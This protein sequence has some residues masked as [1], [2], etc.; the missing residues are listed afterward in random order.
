MMPAPE[1]PA[2]RRFLGRLLT[3]AAGLALPWRARPLVAAPQESTA[4]EGYLGEIMLLAF[5]FPPKNWA[6]CNGQLLSIA[7]NPALFSLL[8]T[9]YGGNGQTT[10]GLP[11]LR[12]RVAMHQ[13]QGAGLSPRS[14]GE[15]SGETSHTLTPSELP[16][17][18]HVARGSS[19]AGSVAMPGNT[20]V[21]ARN[22]AQIP[23]WGTTVDSA[24]S[25]PAAM[26]NV[27]G[28]QPHGNEQPYLVINYVICIAGVFP[29]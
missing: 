29:S 20:V 23:Q 10:F 24:L 5:N 3:L 27:G 21:P 14:M 15:R 26:T 4:A 1:T 28:N 9:T 17:H 13:G 19:A 22:A 6:L 16:S 18:T 11:D 7:Q 12:A 2:R 25:P 8:G